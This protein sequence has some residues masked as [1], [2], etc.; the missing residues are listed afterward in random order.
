MLLFL[1]R[2]LRSSPVPA[3]KAD[4]WTEV[5][6]PH[7]TVLCNDGERTARRIA[8]QFEQI[9]LV[10]SK[11]LSR[12]VR[13]DPSI[14]IQIIASRNEKSLSEIIPEYWAQKGHMH[15][16]GLF[17]PSPEKNYIALRTD[18]KANFRT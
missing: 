17:V 12:N 9:R 1:A 3:D 7:F 8:Q 4:T 5:A 6:S 13:L 16:A 2:N 15:P 18:W 11:A 14:P 10:Y